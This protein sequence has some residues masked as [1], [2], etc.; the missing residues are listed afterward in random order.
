MFHKK[1]YVLH[2]LDFIEVCCSSC[3]KNKARQGWMSECFKPKNGL[4]P[5]SCNPFLN[6]MI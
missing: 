3:E 1:K 2:N 4:Q 6:I 5:N